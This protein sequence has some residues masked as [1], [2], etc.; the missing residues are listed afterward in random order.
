M[1]TQTPGH[2]VVSADFTTSKGAEV[3]IA[4]AFRIVNGEVEAWNMDGSASSELQSEVAAKIGEIQGMNLKTGMVKDRIE[5]AVFAVADVYGNYGPGDVRPANQIGFIIGMLSYPINGHHRLYVGFEPKP[6][7]AT[8]TARFLMP[9]RPAVEQTVPFIAGS[10]F[11]VDSGTVTLTSV[12]NLPPSEGRELLREDKPTGHFV[13]TLSKLF[14]A[15]VQC[16]LLNKAGNP[17]ISADEKGN[18]LDYDQFRALDFEEMGRLYG[19]YR[20]V[21]DEPERQVLALFANPSQIGGI[22]VKVLQEETVDRTGIPARRK[23]P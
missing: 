14:G 3:K 13:L 21:V 4:G 2:R 17:C 19:T 6:G 18:L 9:L 12:S 22:K 5:R 1:Q 11:I 16:A 23:S 10:S 20:Q 7:E 15:K 8:G